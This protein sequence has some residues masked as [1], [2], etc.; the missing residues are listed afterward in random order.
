MEEFFWRVVMDTEE[1]RQW[2][3]NP[4][5]IGAIGTAILTLFQGYG[6]MKQNQVIWSSK[7][8][9]SVSVVFFGYFFFYLAAF[10]IYGLQHKSVAII[11]NGFLLIPTVPI[12]V[13]LWKFKKFTAAEKAWLWFF[14]SIP[15]AMY[16]LKWKDAMLLGFLFGIGIFM[17][18]QLYEFW[19]APGMGELDM[20]MICIFF[21][22]CLFWIV[23][24]WATNKMPLIIFNCIGFFLY[25]GFFSV[26]RRKKRK[27][28]ERHLTEVI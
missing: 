5:T 15:F 18:R 14:A 3:Y 16:F 28:P 12:M 27:Q 9:E 19:A 1:Y 4:A 10:T 24:S 21:V 8:G 25:L 6:L 7:S 20:K 26:W 23:Y 17:A 2:G 22:T 13:G 11:L